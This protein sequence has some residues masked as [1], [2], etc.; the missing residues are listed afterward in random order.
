MKRMLSIALTFAILAV[1]SVAIAATTK[2]NLKS[3]ITGEYGAATKYAAFSKAAADEGYPS[4][5]KLFAATSKAETFH[6]T[7]HQKV[8]GENWLPE[9]PVAKAGTMAENLKAG[10]DGETYEFTKM[11]PGFIEQANKDCNTDAVKSFKTASAAEKNHA[12]LYTAELKNV[13]SLKGVDADWYLCPKC[14]LVAKNGAPDSCSI[15]KVSG[16][17]FIKNPTL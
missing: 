2:E 11:Y 16:K 17:N 5:A 1:S 8:L 4:L 12:E 13:A 9:K 7:S 15:C 3:A 6:V 14:G 10:I